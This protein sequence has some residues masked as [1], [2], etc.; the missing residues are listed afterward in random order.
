MDYFLMKQ[1]KRVKNYVD[2]KIDFFTKKELWTEEEPLFLPCEDTEEKVYLPFL[3]CGV[4]VVSKE[5]KKIFDIYQKGIVSRPII[6]TDLE[7]QWSEICYCMKGKEID[8]L[9]KSTVY[10]KKEIQKI[11]LDTTKVGYHK[12][13][14]IKGIPYHHIV[15]DVEVVERLLRE[16]ITAFDAMILEQEGSESTWEKNML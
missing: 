5:M 16:N 13:F 9:G 15:A 11:S 4:C 2:V 8:C 1:D 10:E 3:D 6:L 12:V 7:A 14:Q